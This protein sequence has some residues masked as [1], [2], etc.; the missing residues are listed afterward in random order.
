MNRLNGMPR[1]AWLTL[2]AIA[3]FVVSASTLSPP[4]S[5]QDDAQA[6]APKPDPYRIP[7]NPIIQ[8]LLDDKATSDAQKRRLAV[9]HG[10]WDHLKEPTL[11][12]RAE[13]ALMSYDL[14]S[15][16][17]RDVKAPVM[18][19]AEAALL[20]GEPE[21]TI[22]LLKEIDT[23]PAA[24]LRAHAFDQQG[25]VRGAIQT[26]TPWR[27]QL[28]TSGLSAAPDIV[29]AA[30]G[31]IL[32]AEL[33]GRPAQDYKQAM[34]F[35]AVARSDIDRL[36]WPASLAEAR[37]LVEKDNPQDALRAAVDVLRLNP[38]CSEAWAMLGQFAIMQFNF[39]NAAIISKKLAKLNANH[40]LATIVDAESFLTQKDSVSARKAIE[41]MLAKYPNHRDLLALLAATEALSYKKDQLAKTLAH[42]DKLTN[43]N[44]LA[45]VTAGSFLSHAR[46]YVQSAELL[47]E[48]VRRRPNHAGPRTELGL[49]LMQQGDEE[50]ALKQLR[51]ATQLDPFNKRA[52]NQLRLVEALLGYEHIET[53]HFVIKYRK[54]IDEALARDMERDIETMYRDVT[55]RLRFKPANKTLIEIMPD[56]E[57]FG[58][59]IT[60][61]PEIWTI[62]ACTGDV[63][64]M[65]PPRDGPKQRGTYDWY[66]VLQHEYTHTVTL[67]QT[68]F[69]IPHWLTEAVSVWMEPGARDFDTSQLLA[70]ALAN[71]RLFNL[72]TINWGF[73]RPR[74]PTDRPLA[75]A[76]GHWMVQY[77]VEKY[78]EDTVIQMLN[79][80]RRGIPEIEGFEQSTGTRADEFIKDFKVWAKRQVDSW[81]LA[82]RGDEAQVQQRIKAVSTVTD[83]W[84]ADM[85]K[86]F[87]DHPYVLR[88]A[89]EHAIK[90]DK[91]PIETRSLILRYAMMRPVDPWAHQALYVLAIKQGRIDEAI[92]ALIQAERYEISSG[93]WGHELAKLYRKKKQYGQ[94][95]GALRRA[96]HREPYNAG[97]RELAG[98]VALQARDFAA[99]IHEV[100]ALTLLE[101]DRAQHFLRL[102]ALYQ[103][104]G[105]KDRMRSAATK[106]KQLDPKAPVERFLK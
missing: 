27:R 33:E 28:I 16:A 82:K 58:V 64:A 72:R 8:R 70:S 21:N 36:Y 93:K 50:E 49:M 18:F 55:E 81:G 102:A 22:K 4:V 10:H 23:A 26:L 95:Y 96:L 105:D 2:A 63:V 101:P 104:T 6:D 106:A 69:R 43:K 100:R 40:L 62:A 57:W 87:P 38:K 61:L 74:T 98:A 60:G 19:R 54:G 78:S 92:G 97:Y 46:Q 52:R 42:F 86:T 11:A 85:V 59:R 29:A 51:L 20:R 83:A 7:V 89:T 47:Q 66:R 44:P 48:A 24:L 53:D 25:N 67:N 77:I 76:Q 91:D 103:L 88:L 99:A 75:Y 12:E 39:E 80:Y 65:A 15:E 17:L 41:P 9:F 45:H 31:M 5:A 14:E 37:I 3:F 1:L 30:E 35:L 73:I 68:F 84:V 94:A 90:K 13:M 34:Q 56:E 79:L 32:L 71:D